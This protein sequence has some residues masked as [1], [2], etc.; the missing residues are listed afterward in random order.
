MALG[1]MTSLLLGIGLA[2]YGTL[3]YLVVL[4]VR[5]LRKYLREGGRA[6]PQQAEL[7]RSLGQAI[8]AQRTRCSMTQEYVAERLGVSRQ[9]VSKWENGTS[10]PSTANL[11]ALATL[12]GISV[13]ELLRGA[14]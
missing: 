14:N 3:I 8:K 11:L 1:Y 7:Q 9:A 4:L 12:F 5:A 10:D 13:D 2:V 6:Q